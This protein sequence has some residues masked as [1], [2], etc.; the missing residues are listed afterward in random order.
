[1]M[2]TN[3]DPFD[4]PMVAVQIERAIEPYRAL[5]TPDMLA[6]FR[7]QLECALMTDPVAQD[8]LRRLRPRPAVQASG[9]ATIGAVAEEF[10]P[11]PAKPSDRSR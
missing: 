1:M 7:E 5:L 4:D 9:E 11:A 6:A 2:S 10:T 3:K 8:L